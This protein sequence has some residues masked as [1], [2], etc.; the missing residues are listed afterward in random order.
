VL[1]VQHL[2]K[3]F[4]SKSIVRDVSFAVAP[5]EAFGLLG[6]NGAGKSTTIAMICGLLAPDAGEIRVG[7]IDLRQNPRAVRQLMGVVPQEIALYPSLSARENL[8][9]WGSL[10]G[11][12]GRELGSRVDEALET[13]ALTHRQKERIATFSGGMKRRI[14]IAAALLHRPQLL[15]MDEPTVGIDPQSRNHILETVKRLN[16]EQGLTVLYTSHYME[17]VQ[18][19][20]GRL[21]I[22]DHGEVIAAG[23]LDAVRS[24]VPLDTAVC[25][26]GLKLPS[27]AVA[28]P[29]LETVFL[30]L[31][32][33]TLRD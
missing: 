12:T 16:A 18:Y 32:G 20:C 27:R 13:V 2:I 4:G 7:G 11:L 22:L 1:E 31:T 24:L 29:S 6:P 25:A 10:Y 15:I 26:S 33:R 21:A 8:R 30:H 19:L 5:G 9:F 14:N 3:R 17:E 23:S 28:E